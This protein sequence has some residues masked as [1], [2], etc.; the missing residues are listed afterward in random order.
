MN[1]YIEKAR[2]AAYFAH[3]GQQYGSA[4]YIT[5]LDH[6]VDVLRRFGVL[7]DGAVV[8]YVAAY[9]HD[10]LEDTDA[11]FHDLA[12][13]FSPEVA[14][15]VDAVTDQPGENR[16]ERHLATYPRIRAAGVRAILVKMAD[17]I[18]NVETSVRGPNDKKLMMYQSEYAEFRG[19]LFIPGGAA[20][21]LM[22]MWKHLDNLLGW[23]DIRE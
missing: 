6:A 3:S 16:K 15:L 17:R 4:H 13:N 12:V 9:L 21:P 22:A 20:G 7:E 8:V 10:T 5:H 14:F 23:E 1:K 19:A 18:A 11:T 2:V